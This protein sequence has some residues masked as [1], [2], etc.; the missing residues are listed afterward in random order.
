MDTSELR[1]IILN[2]VRGYKAFP[3]EIRVGT[4][5]LTIDLKKR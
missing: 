2:Q 1:E 4:N 3:I 5:V